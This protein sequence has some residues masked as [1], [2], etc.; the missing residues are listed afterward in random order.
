MNI[1][2]TIKETI[3]DIGKEYLK[4]KAKSLSSE[5]KF[6]F[7]MWEQMGELSNL[8]KDDIS[9]DELKN[10]ALELSSKIFKQINIITALTTELSKNHA[11]GSD[12]KNRL[13]TI[14]STLKEIT[15]DTKLLAEKSGVEKDLLDLVDSLGV[16]AET[17]GDLMSRAENLLQLSKGT[18]DPGLPEMF[19]GCLD[20]VQQSSEFLSGAVSGLM[21][22]AKEDIK[23]IAKEK[24]KEMVQEKLAECTPNLNRVTGM[25]A[26]AVAIAPVEM[27]PDEVVSLFSIQTE[28]I[29]EVTKPVVSKV[30]IDEEFQIVFE[31]QNQTAD[32]AGNIVGNAEIIKDI[33]NTSV[34]KISNN[35]TQSDLERIA[36]E[37]ADLSVKANELIMITE[38]DPM[39]VELESF[40][41]AIADNCCA[42]A[43]GFSG[44]TTAIAKTVAFEL[45]DK[46]LT[47]GID[48]IQE[49]LSN[50]V[51]KT[52][53]TAKSNN[54][55]DETIGIIHKQLDTANNTGKILA[56]ASEIADRS[57]IIK[58]KAKIETTVETV[59]NMSMHA[60]EMEAIIYGID[61]L[62]KTDPSLL[63]LKDYQEGV[64]SQGE[65]LE[66]SIA[67]LTGFT[68][69]IAA[70]ET[71]PQIITAI[72]DINERNSKIKATQEEIKAETLAPIRTTSSTTA[73]PSSETK[74]TQETATAQEAASSQA[75]VPS[76]D[77][78]SSQ[79]KE[80]QQDKEPSANAVHESGDITT[81]SGQFADQQSANQRSQNQIPDAQKSGE[82]LSAKAQSDSTTTDTAKDNSVADETASAQSGTDNLGVASAEETK[83]SVEKQNTDKIA[84]TDSNIAEEQSVAA[85]SEAG[86]ETPATS[87]AEQ[88]SQGTFQ[89]DDSE[90]ISKQLNKDIPDTQAKQS[91]NINSASSLNGAEEKIHKEGSIAGAS[92]LKEAG[93]K[94]TGIKE[95]ALKGNFQQQTSVE[96]KQS[97]LDSIENNLNVEDAAGQKIAGNKLSQKSAGELDFAGDKPDLSAENGKNSILD[98]ADSI[99]STN[100]IS[101]DKI[102]REV[103]DKNSLFD[104][105]MDSKD[106]T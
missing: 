39:E 99:K 97:S 70:N 89:S 11:I 6:L 57:S 9:V 17:C 36:R 62:T 7:E 29:A 25:V 65:Q 19:T 103:K 20:D 98:K 18:K 14:T 15:A 78:V 49:K 37:A 54:T 41:E 63:T 27:I 31:K 106:K 92:G 104:N 68:Q 33:S 48:K 40:T 28:S 46:T 55:K 50:A 3:V 69:K 60:L 91:E 67:G 12:F 1:G 21:D 43:P 53:K 80:P 52:T 88:L 75:A 102:S 13:E 100:N 58:S 94:E 61:D 35:T 42:F 5:T 16:V 26:K 82:S 38:I 101:T 47:V 44:I 2:N 30:N 81:E 24:L 73:S 4:E 105:I 77:A 23:S 76:Q 93:I 71:D 72:G 32:F 95:D 34:G 45:F 10:K 51:D 86:K 22:I 66:T 90:K 96:S 79:D 85:S 84:A 8:T 64:L 83:Q 56:C 59:N 87:R 74:A